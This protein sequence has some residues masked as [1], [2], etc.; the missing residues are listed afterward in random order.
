MDD[1]GSSSWLTGLAARAAGSMSTPLR[2]Y[3]EHG[4]GAG[5]TA[6]EAAAAWGELRLRPHVL[7]DVTDVDLEAGVVVVDA[8]TG[9]LDLDSVED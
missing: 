1:P 4:A 9:L 5:V 3:V 8:P 6:G 2:E 7:R